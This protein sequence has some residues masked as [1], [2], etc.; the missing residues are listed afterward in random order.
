MKPFLFALTAAVLSQFAFANPVRSNSWRIVPN[1]EVCMV[2]DM[3]FGRPQIPVVKEGKT[4]YGC[5]ENC[6]A[7]IQKDAKAIMATDPLTKK[8]VDKA[9]ATIAADSKGAVMY[10]E[11]KSNF[12]KYFGSQAKN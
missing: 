9:K 6:K 1:N 10:F 8:T 12:Q 11:N 5:C 7:T 4:Y 2:T 3:H